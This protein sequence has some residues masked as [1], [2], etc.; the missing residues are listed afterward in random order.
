MLLLRVRR[1]NPLSGGGEILSF[2]P[3]VA[4]SGGISLNHSYMTR[5]YEFYVYI[6]ASASRTLYVGF[7]NSLERR[8]SEHKQ[9]LFEGFTKKYQCHSL[10]YYETYNDVQVAIAREK[11]LKRWRREKKVALINSVNPQWK[12]L[13]EEWE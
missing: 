4:A 2:R 8:V 13:S 12:D 10:V 7:S 5:R 9:D 1:Y 11:Q 6:M 3:S